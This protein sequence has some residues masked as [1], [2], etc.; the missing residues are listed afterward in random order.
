M[1]GQISFSHN[2]RNTPIRISHGRPTAKAV[3]TA[4]SALDRL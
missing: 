3:M 2:H 4:A 1:R